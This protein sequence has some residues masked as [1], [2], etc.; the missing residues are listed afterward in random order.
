M[1]DLPRF[2][3]A[4]VQTSPVYLDPTATTEKACSIIKEAAGKGASLIAFPEVFIAGYPY[5]NW[6]LNPIQGSK[7]YER[8]YKSAITVPGPEVALL[9]KTAKEHSIHVVMGINERGESLANDYGGVNAIMCI[10]RKSARSEFWP[11]AKI[12]TRWL[13]LHFLHRAS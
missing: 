9:C 7:W 12:P 10:Q 1:K 8:L 11:V 13:V 2:K 5:W 4:A 3:A 6:V